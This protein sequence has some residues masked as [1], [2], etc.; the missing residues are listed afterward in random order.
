MVMMD[1]ILCSVITDELKNGGVYYFIIF[2][3]DDD[4]MGGCF[5]VK[6]VA[7]APW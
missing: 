1:D 6:N 3:D 5:F 2:Y 7:F 4:E